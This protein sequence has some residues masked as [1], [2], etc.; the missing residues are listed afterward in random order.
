MKKRIIALLLSF[1]IFCGA[2]SVSKRASAAPAVAWGII[3][4]GIVAWEL[5]DLMIKGEEPG[6]VVAMET[7]IESGVDGLTNPDSPFQQNWSAFWNNYGT[8]WEAMCDWLTMKIDIGEIIP[9]DE[10]FKLT[11]GQYLEACKQLVS[12]ISAPTVKFQSDYPS[13]FFSIDG[14]PINFPPSS[15]PTVSSFLNNYP[16]E[17]YALCYYNDEQIVF[18]SYC[19]AIYCDD[20]NE[21][22]FYGFYYVD[23]NFSLNFFNEVSTSYYQVF[24][25]PETWFSF[26]S[27]SAAS[28]KF[29]SWDIER[30]FSHCFVYSNG[31][32][33]YTPISEVD[34]TGF[35]YGLV[36]T[37]WDY[38]SFLKSINDFSITKSDVGELDDLST[39]LPTEEN[40]SLSIPTNPALDKPIADQVMVG[41]I[42]GAD[43]LPLSDYINNAII[44]T[45]NVPSVIVKKFPFCIPF[46]FI[47]FLGVLA[48]DP[49]PPVFRIP[50][51]TSPKN[52]EQWADNETVGHYV[53]PDEPMF[54][55]NEE[56]VLDFAHIPLVQPICYTV[57]IV[58]FVI[59]LIHITTK[60]I[61]H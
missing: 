21:S 51:S 53:A 57:F 50:I 49:V 19:I 60:H 17:S 8:G 55:I 37:V 1:S 26:F 36:S 27:L 6:I 16:G 56:I 43:D 41:D 5:L 23:K 47:R 25:N 29:P 38:G 7:L 33:S 44:T 10:L 3:E 34:L 61:Q 20:S 2:L 59:L 11:Y 32:V 4:I 13:F 18:S 14:F 46:D 15:L 35:N 31:V 52:L 45:V 58:G 30:N 22:G 12:V 9:E 24:E 39:V 40:P 54:K 42:A 48:A 28:S